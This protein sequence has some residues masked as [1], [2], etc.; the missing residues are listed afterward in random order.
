MVAVMVSC[1][2]NF[3]G[4]KLRVHIVLSFDYC[5]KL[6]LIALYIKDMHQ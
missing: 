1:I 4:Y 2:L 6:L 5:P 3:P